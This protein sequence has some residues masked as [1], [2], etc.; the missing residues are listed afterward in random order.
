MIEQP[1][2]HSMKIILFTCFFLCFS[3][4][5][6]SQTTAQ[7][8]QKIA[9]FCKL[10]GFLKYY[11][12]AVASGK[13]DWDEEFLTRIKDLNSLHSKPE[14]SNYYLQWIHGLGKVRDCKNCNDEI[15]DSLAFNLELAWLADSMLITEPLRNEL[16]FIRNNRNQDKNYY[17]E[18]IKFV[19]N[20]AF[21]N[22]KPYQD[23]IYPSVELRLLGLSRYWNIINYFYPYKYIIG[24]AWDN[25][26]L[27]MTPKFKDAQ[28]TVAYHLAMLELTTK[29]NDTHAV[30]STPYTNRYFGLKWAPFQFTIIDNK[31]VVTGFYNDSLCK[32]ND[33]QF[34]D[35]FLSVGHLSIADIIREKSKYIGASNDAAR[36]RNMYYAVF[37]GQTDSVEATF[38]RNGEISE[39]TIYRYLFSEFGY[40]GSEGGTQDTCTIWDGN[41]G[42]VNL[43]LLQPKQTERCLNALRDTKAIV[44]DVRNYPNGTMYQIANFLNAS[45][46]PFARF[47]SPDLSYPGVFQYTQPYT[48]GRNNEAPYAGRVILLFN[49]TTQSHAEFTLMALQTAPRVISI[50]SQTAGAD[51]NVSSITFPGNYKT[52]MTGIGVYYPDGRETQRIG[53]VPD[54][55]VKPT[56]EGLRLHRDE[57]IEKAIE[58][59][60]NE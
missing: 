38:E 11:H 6:F 52:Y 50:G 27:E 59:I 48:C 2:G 56:L 19:G 4:A 21:P 49:A 53:I 30:F 10:W 5:A 37:N 41:I 25:V 3:A 45:S 16:L 51:G 58:I 34:G 24:Q 20:T 26:L 28:D 18:Q 29:I 12:P 40:K 44:F 17:V 8:S 7:E 57:L 47:T 55:E 35:V 36:I 46:K 22:E 39:K 60:G 32:L 31:A 42:Y 1:H 9:T 54:I 15:P 13:Q 33:I 14:I 43:G 23:S